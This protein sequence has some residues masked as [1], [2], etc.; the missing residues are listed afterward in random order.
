MEIT[1]GKWKVVIHRIGGHDDKYIT[2]QDEDGRT[3]LGMVDGAWEEMLANARLIAVS[4]KMYK[5]LIKL[6][7]V[8]FMDFHTAY[9]NEQNEALNNAFTVIDEAEKGR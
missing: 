6:H 1:N 5:A 8:F 2:V 9:T 4:P 3:L 7:K